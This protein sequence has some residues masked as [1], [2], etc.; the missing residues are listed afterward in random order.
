MQGTELWNFRRLEPHNPQMRQTSSV[1]S[2][3]SMLQCKRINI[4]QVYLHGV[5][6]GE[7]THLSHAP[8]HRSVSLVCR[9]ACPR[10]LQQ[11]EREI[12]PSVRPTARTCRMHH[13][14]TAPSP[15][16]LKHAGL[17]QHS[18]LLLVEMLQFCGVALAKKPAGIGRPLVSENECFNSL[19][20]L[21]LW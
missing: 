4:L 8:L 12:A 19:L 11:T 18:G 7:C 5:L 3:D 6:C 17:R 10:D 21:V 20:M 9:V 1:N 15:S 2:H 16:C 14:R 13:K